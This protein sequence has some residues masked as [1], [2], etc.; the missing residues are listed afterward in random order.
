MQMDALGTLLAAQRFGGFSIGYWAGY[1][2][3][4]PL[5]LPM[6]TS[7]LWQDHVMAVYSPGPQHSRSSGAFSH[8][9]V[10]SDQVLDA[11]GLPV[12]TGYEPQPLSWSP[13]QYWQSLR[14]LARPTHSCTPPT[15]RFYAFLALRLNPAS[16]R[17][18]FPHP[19]L[20]VTPR[21]T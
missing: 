2:T 3:F 20:P 5:I 18:P 11:L 10:C 21:V 17:C 7:P 1:W 9:A 4:P 12:S 16:I 6:H 8:C 15:S 19:S 14:C 13:H